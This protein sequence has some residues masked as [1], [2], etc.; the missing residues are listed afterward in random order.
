M[1]QKIV[2]HSFRPTNDDRIGIGVK[3]Q[4]VHDDGNV[5][6][7]NNQA[8]A[9]MFE[10]VH[11]GFIAEAS[12]PYHGEIF[13]ALPIEAEVIAIGRLGAGETLAS[14]AEGD[15]THLE[16]KF[17]MASDPDGLLESFNEGIKLSFNKADHRYVYQGKE[18]VSGT[19]YIK[20]WI[21]EFD[22]AFIAG[23]VADKYGV[24][25]RQVED[26]WAGGG[27]VSA[28]FGT[29]IHNALEHYEKFRNLGSTIQ[30]QKQLPHNPALPTHPFLRRIVEDFY[31]LPLMQGTVV[32][33][34]LVTNVERGLCGFVD[35]LLITGPMRARVQDYKI[36]INS[37]AIDPNIKY[38]G[39]MKD[40]PKNK[41]SK[42]QL[43]L[44]FYA[45]L[46]ELSGWTIEGL[47]VF[48]FEDT[49]KQYD[50]PVLKLDF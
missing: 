49:W 12:N 28:T 20:K 32:P 40:L 33:E 37:E 8:I 38:L 30:L 4:L 26:Y 11:L 36:N 21:S 3:V 17:P 10:D 44:S 14:F 41:L 22:A 19:K 6:S 43:Q 1:I 39:I 42:Y 7:K 9:V 48:V 25:P 13:Q 31:K 34:A 45:R 16:I 47:T 15:I 46:L 5:H 18:L 2:G 27:D 24:T 35:R 29:A 50:L 23:K